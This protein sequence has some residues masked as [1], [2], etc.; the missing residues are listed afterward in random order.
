MQEFVQEASAG[1]LNRRPTFKKRAPTIVKTARGNPEEQKQ[2]AF[3]DMT[4]KEKL[5]W[6]KEQEIIRRQE[7]LRKGA[8]MAKENYQFAKDRKMQV[9]FDQAM[10]EAN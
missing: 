2:K 3:E 4:P 10:E 8:S 9:I 7:E 5:A 6:K 1:T